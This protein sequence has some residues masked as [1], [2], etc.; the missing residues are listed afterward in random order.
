MK[1][2]VKKE[3]STAPTKPM[4]EVPSKEKKK[5]S[6]SLKVYQKNEDLSISE[7]EKVLLEFLFPS[8]KCAKCGKS[9][10]PTKPEYVYG[11]CCSYP[12]WLHRDDN[13]KV[14]HAKPVDM[15]SKEG[16]YLM[17]FSN[18]IEAAHYV[19]LAKPDNIRACCLGKIKSSGGFAWKYKED[20]T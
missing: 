6:F 11:D 18:S 10:T 13:K 3:T 12:C 9:F 16:K 4:V 17:S 2:D 19:G 8:K 7:E 15:Y 14:P 1:T 5:K 20:Q